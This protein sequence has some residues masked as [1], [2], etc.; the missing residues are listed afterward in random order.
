ML[1][2][3]K[4]SSCSFD[5]LSI[6]W[7]S[8]ALRAVGGGLSVTLHLERHDEDESRLARQCKEVPHG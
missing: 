5:H 7:R 6:C 8:R 4:S 3:A 1:R 2:S